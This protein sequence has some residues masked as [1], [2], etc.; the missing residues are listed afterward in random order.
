V[1]GPVRGEIT[2]LK[3]N[4]RRDLARGGYVLVRSELVAFEPDA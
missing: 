4:Y 3:P 2:K 1:T